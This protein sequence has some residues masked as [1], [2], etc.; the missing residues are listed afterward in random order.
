[1]RCPEC[2]VLVCTA[3][4]QRFIGGCD[5][6]KT[7]QYKGELFSMVRAAEAG[8][9]AGGPF[10][11]VDSSAVATSAPLPL[12]DFP[13]VADDRVVR[14]VGVMVSPMPVHPAQRDR[15]RQTFIKSARC[16]QQF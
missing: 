10:S 5:S 7:L 6:L 13:P 14:A 16:L 15:A 1:M 9:E 8:P 12:F 11:G 3:R 2:D 4:A